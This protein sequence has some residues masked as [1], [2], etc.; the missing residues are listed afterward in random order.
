MLRRCVV[1]VA[2]FAVALPGLGQEAEPGTRERL[3]KLGALVKDGRL[4]VEADLRQG[5]VPAIPKYALEVQ[6][7]PRTS[8]SADAVHGE[9]TKMH[10]TVE[11]GKLVVRGKGLR[12]KVSIESLDFESP[13][14]ITNL[15]FKGLGIW[16][17]ILAVF[18][19]IARSAVGKM[20]IRTDIP[21]VLKGEILGAKKALDAAGAAP[22][23]TPP[24]AAASSAGPPAAPTPS[25]MDLVNEVR[26]NEMTLT[27]F[28]GRRMNLRPFLEFQ[29]AAHPQSGEAM[30]LSIGK[31]VFRPGRDGAPD[32]LEIS[33]TLDGEIE[34]GSMEFGANR[35]AIARGRIQG[36]TYHARSGE[37]GKITA[38]FSSSNVFFELSSG[39]FVVPGGLRVELE[40]GSIFDVADVKVTSGGAFSGVA[41]LDLAGQT[42][43]FARKGAKIS[44]SNV[45]LHSQGL[46]IVNGRATGPVELSFDYQLAYL[47]VVKYP[48]EEIA[49]K[50]LMLDFHGPFATTLQLSDAGGEEGEVTGSYVFKAPWAPIE[51]AALAALEAKWQ[52]DLAIKHV[53][54]SIVPRKFRP[55][56]LSCF[57][58][59][60]E[61]TAEKKKG[62]KKLFSQFCAPIGMAELYVDKPARSFVLK[63]VRIEPHCKGV[64]GWV[65]NFI[66]PL[67]AKTYGDLVLFQMPPG[68]PLSIDS[69]RGGAEWIEIGGSVDWSAG[70]GQE[71]VGSRQ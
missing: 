7:N 13:K 48:I 44:T 16:K 43:E 10:F 60:L 23:P 40:S 52:Q 65:V 28:E 37:D 9:I 63:D 21:S 22:A 32:F 14:G 35:S 42:G 46:S 24:P 55:C 69:V 64:V 8:I 62:L 15:K 67:L 26:I 39:T 58:L 68:L 2:L 6:G 49:A 53:D 51:Q 57:T 66:A 20:A 45:K 47:F 34:D 12:P 30:R 54:F 18:G 31:G 17:P 1:L 19:G 5:S 29:T 50:K 71:A 25:F 33:G 36:G 56:G 61:I 3:D 38:A 27:A 59:E 41:K 70:G 11:N 4:D